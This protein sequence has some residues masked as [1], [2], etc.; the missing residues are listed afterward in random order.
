MPIRTCFFDMGNV[1]VF[2]SHQRMVENVARLAGW[3]PERVRTFLFEDG[4]QWRL[5]RGELTEDQFHTEFCASVGTHVERSQ[6]LHACADIFELNEP[7]VPLL[8]QL[9]NKGLQLVLL[10]N[11]S[12]THLE[13]IERRWSILQL[14]HHRVVSYEV[15]AMK[16]DERIFQAALKAA[17]GSP[18]EC[19]YTDDMAPFIARAESLGIRSHQFV[20]PAAL[21]AALTDL[22]IL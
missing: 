22:N 19:F 3:P 7:M 1:L 16:P 8:Q 21:T 11:T 2:F 13:F 5:E 15:G 18:Q 6:L 14:L 20:S 12:R 10:S 17:H 9:R 4:R